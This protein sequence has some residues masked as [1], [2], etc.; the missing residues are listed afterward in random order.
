MVFYNLS[1]ANQPVKTSVLLGG[2]EYEA[3]TDA[4]MT[5]H[6]RKDWPDYSPSMYRDILANPSSFIL[7]TVVPGTGQFPDSVARVI[8]E[9]ESYLFADILEGRRWPGAFDDYLRGFALAN[10]SLAIQTRI[11]LQRVDLAPGTEVF[12]EGGFRQNQNYGALLGAMLPEN[13]LF[14][15]ELEEATS[16]GA[17]LCAKALADGVSVESLKDFVSLDKKS[18]EPAVLDGLEGYVEAFLGNLES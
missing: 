18:I 1:Y 11:A 3:Y 13:P 8:D 14:L 10:L 12:I 5:H 16:Y 7:P 17:A 2:L 9:G 15:T 6:K 4:L